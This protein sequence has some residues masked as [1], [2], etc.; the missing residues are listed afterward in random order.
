M[1]RAPEL[2]A[3][4]GIIA[5]VT[6]GYVLAVPRGAGEPGASVGH[7]LGI[8]GL[9]LMLGTEVLY[10]IRKR[11]K[12]RA[13]GPMRT[14]LRAHVVTGLVGPYLI[15][16]HTAGHLHGAGGWAAIATAVVVVSGFTGR[17]LYTAIPRAIDGQ[18]LSSV[19]IDAQLSSAEL[20]L[21]GTD[22]GAKER[23][24][25]SSDTRRL[26]RRATAA[27]A[28]R[29]LLAGWHTIHVPL[30]LAMFTLVVIHVAIAVY[31]GAGMR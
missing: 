8:L 23:K 24:R 17:Y 1:R 28:M 4:L 13:W 21:S 14:W 30:S 16:L 31:Y 22:L 7:A 18:V 10:S 27:D 19:E 6:V 26:Q 5:L 2:L 9:V 12:D 15:A 11:A 20:R 29:K 25:L 3:A